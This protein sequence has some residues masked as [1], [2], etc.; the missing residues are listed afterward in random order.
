MLGL[1]EGGD[2]YSVDFNRQLLAEQEFEEIEVH[3]LKGL[4]VHCITA[5]KP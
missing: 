4:P 3:R 1:T 2:C 5:D